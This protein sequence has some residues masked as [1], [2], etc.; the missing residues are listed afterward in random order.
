MD[1]SKK[2]NIHYL[3]LYRYE[4]PV[5][6]LNGQYLCKHRLDKRLLEERLKDIEDRR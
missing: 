6:F 3:R 4:I 2:E 5:V 1:I